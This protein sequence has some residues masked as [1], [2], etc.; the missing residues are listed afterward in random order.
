LTTPE[1]NGPNHRILV[2]DDNAVIHDDFRKILSSR[3]HDDDLE[4]D[5]AL[6]FGAVAVATPEFDVDSAYQG[7]D[8][9]AAV[10]HALSEDRPYAL[11]FV[12][13]RMP[14]GWDGVETIAQL[15]LAD[16][17]LQIVICT[18]YSDYSW[19]DIWLRLGHPDGLLILKKPFDNIEV[20]QLA[21]ALTAKWMLA[22]QAA[23]RMAELNRIAAE[24][25]R[26]NQQIGLELADKARAELA[27]RTIFQASPVGITLTDSEGCYLDANPAFETQHGVARERLIGRSEA[28]LGLLHAESRET[29]RRDPDGVVNGHEVTYAGPAGDTRTALLWSR[30]VSIGDSSHRLT[31]CVDITDRK[32]MEEELRKARI[33]AEAAST[34]KSEFLA[35][36][37]HEIRTPINGILGFTQLA[38]DTGLTADQRDYLETVESS[39][40]SLLKVINDILDFSKMES[41]HLELEEAPFSL[42]ECVK[43]AITTLSVTARQ[44]ALP[45]LF[46]MAGESDLVI[47]DVVRLRQVLLNIIGN[48]IKF[49]RAGSVRVVVHTTE[50]PEH[51]CEAHFRVEDTGVGIPQDKR[52]I[53]FEP[54]RQSDSSIN[55]KYGGT[56]LGLTISAQLVEKMGGRLW[57][58]SEEG[59]G[60]TFQFI[61][62]FNLSPRPGHSLCRTSACACSYSF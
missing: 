43:D 11:A 4:S 15:R 5:E 12:D 41:G 45:L 29:L 42:R 55:R 35:N 10:K 19:K 23:A 16:P 26:A 39:T 48:A 32:Q 34:A 3:G 17:H 40:L 60:S 2:I 21:H 24:L 56:G 30:A 62:P 22:R 38:L 9:L 36:M 37:S 47:G 31:F 8:G 33:A 6:L 61:I 25:Q 49:T 27:F 57:V 59:V 7:Q 1:L 52:K 58:D 50:T 14:P 51:K 44:K 20:I 46:N 13:V 28:D 18:A 53:I 54:F